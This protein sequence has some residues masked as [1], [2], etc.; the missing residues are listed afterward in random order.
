MKHPIVFV[1]LNIV[2]SAGVALGLVNFLGGQPVGETEVL[3]VTIPVIIT[4]TPNPTGDAVRIAAAVEATVESVR[5]DIRATQA[6]VDLPPDILA[7]LADSETLTEGGNV[8]SEGIVVVEGEP[9]PDGCVIH[10]VAEGD[11]PFGI[12]EQYDVGFAAIMAAN[13]LTE[14][15]ARGLQIG[16]VLVVPLA[17]CPLDEI[18]PPATPTL[19]P[20]E[21]ATEDEQ[22]D[23]SE[24]GGES[25]VISDGTPDPDATA[26]E[27]PTAT[28]TLALAPTAT[29][30]QVEIT[31]FLGVGDITSEGVTIVNR[32]NAVNVAGWTLTDAQGNEF[33]FPEQR[34][35]TNGSVTVYTRSGDN[36]PI[37]LFWNRSAAV[38]GDESDV[39]TLRNSEGAVQSSVR[40]GG[41]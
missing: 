9:L 12:A 31:E 22:A 7:D 2:I 18:A 1:I 28:P 24:G 8:V 10:T 33:V 5:A 25:D 11:T 34:L 29:N 35:F 4:S 3:S 6:E 38:W 19:L 39:A 17:N 36:T 40:V 30:A 32:G 14:D 41:E 13:G 21:A 20:T 16:D 37:I 27:S 26:V 23:I 15:T